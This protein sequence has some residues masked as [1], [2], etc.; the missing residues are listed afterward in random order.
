[1]LRGPA[2]YQVLIV[3]SSAIIS[4]EK[5][6]LVLGRLQFGLYKVSPVELSRDLAKGDSANKM[7][8]FLHNK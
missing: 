7:S 2:K 8:M 1:M 6:I 5:T 4:N 3:M